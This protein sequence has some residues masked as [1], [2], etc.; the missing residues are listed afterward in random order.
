MLANLFARHER[1]VE[2]VVRILLG[3]ALVCFAFVGT[4]TKW[5]LFGVMLLAM[6]WAG[7]CDSTP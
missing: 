7:T 1:D 5:G 2:R 6:R 3:L 4:Q